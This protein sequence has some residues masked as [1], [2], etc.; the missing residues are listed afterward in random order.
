M[1]LWLKFCYGFHT[2]LDV[3]TKRWY[4]WYGTALHWWVCIAQEFNSSLNNNAL[5]LLCDFLLLHFCRW[6]IAWCSNSSSLRRSSNCPRRFSRSNSIMQQSTM[7]LL[8]LSKF[9][10][11]HAQLSN[12]FFP[13][14]T[15]W[16]RLL[17]SLNS[18]RLQVNGSSGK[19]TNLA[20]NQGLCHHAPVPHRCHHI[21]KLQV[22]KVYLCGCSCNKRPLTIKDM[23]FGSRDTWT[24]KGGSIVRNCYRTHYKLHMTLYS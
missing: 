13:S 1:D 5:I 11:L 22:S 14:P 9:R 17:T 3:F 15:N 4:Q 18:G 10:R 21:D 20:K 6:S 2:L 12:P 7:S 23:Y 24:F 8:L 19:L 16:R